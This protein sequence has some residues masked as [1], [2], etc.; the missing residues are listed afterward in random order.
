[1]S[2]SINYFMS[3]MHEQLQQYFDVTWK[4]N[5]LT[6]HFDPASSNLRFRLLSCIFSLLKICYYEIYI[7]NLGDLKYE[8]QQVLVRF[9]QWGHSSHK[10]KPTSCIMKLKCVVQFAKLNFN[11]YT[12]KCFNQILGEETMQTPKNG[13]DELIEKLLYHEFT[14]PTIII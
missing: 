10:M 2:S 9:V 3:Q 14:T 11:F 6:K 7:I 8:L 5:V 13:G 4:I 12:N 1:M